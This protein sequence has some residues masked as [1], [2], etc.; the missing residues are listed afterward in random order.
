MW[1]EQGH[2]REVGDIA[3][4]GHAYREGAEIHAAA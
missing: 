4:V 1:L 3:S 2:V